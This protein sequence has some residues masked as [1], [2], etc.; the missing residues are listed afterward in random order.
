MASRARLVW[1]YATASDHP[2]V[3]LGQSMK[4]E[5]TKGSFGKPVG[6]VRTSN[7][8]PSIRLLDWQLFAGACLAIGDFAAVS[9]CHCPGPD[10]LLAEPRHSAEP[11]VG[12]EGVVTCRSRW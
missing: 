9:R 2:P 4:G 10:R 3:Q 11:R 6:A 8:C 7:G 5:K 12:N 1:S